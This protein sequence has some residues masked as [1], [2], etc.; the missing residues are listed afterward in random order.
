MVR[1]PAGASRYLILSDGPMTDVAIGPY[2]AIPKVTG[3]WIITETVLALLLPTID[4]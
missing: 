3:V 2:D 1:F 4:R